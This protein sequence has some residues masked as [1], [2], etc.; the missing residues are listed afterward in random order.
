MATPTSRSTRFFLDAGVGAAMAIL[1]THPAHSASPTR[2]A[3]HHPPAAEKTSGAAAMAPPL[4]GNEF[5]PLHEGATIA[6]FALEA[7]YENENGTR[8]GARFRHQPSGFV[9]DVLRIQSLPQAFVW[10]NTPP[11]TD[12][13]EPHTLEHL[14][15]GKGT[16]GR[17]VASLEDMCLGESSAYTE[18]WRTCYHFHTAAG[19]DVFFRLFEEK[20]DAMLH[21]TYSDEEIRR[22]VC[23]MGIIELE[24]GTLGL[25]EKGTVYN[26]MVST[27]ERPWGYLWDQ[28]PRL[29]YGPSHPLAVSSGGEPAAI[30]ELTP[31]EIRA[32]HAG[33]HHLSNMGAV[34]SIGDELSLQDC[35]SRLSATFARIEPDAKSGEDP[36][37]LVDRLPPP[38]PAER[39]AIAHVHFPNQNPNEPGVMVMA[40]PAERDLDLDQHYLAGLFVDALASGE[41]SNLYRK[42]ID[43]RTPAID[44]GS[45][46]VFG[47]LDSDPGQPIF[48]GF[49]NVAPKMAT[50]ETARR[51]R[52][53]VL[54]EIRAI[55]SWAPD[56][57][58]LAAFNARVRNLL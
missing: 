41:T 16:K 8:I 52:S 12:Q 6:D 15:L 33:T 2:S 39:G 49:S 44:L 4:E 5:D 32:F 56:S 45:N 38:Q 30:R 47:W 3:A 27:Y 43:S 36:A 11:P 55:A 24:D 9:L 20:L 29:L 10:V 57:P 50:D 31:E 53:M 28:L 19:A 18:Q 23:N 1:A 46:E 17:Y 37:N 54:D 25:E 51:V 48:I 13:G 14:L 21:P 22:E 58:E 40:W 34:I 7:V 26:E 42:F 35:L